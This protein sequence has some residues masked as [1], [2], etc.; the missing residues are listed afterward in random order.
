MVKLLPPLPAVSFPHKFA[1]GRQS[2]ASQAELKVSFFSH[3]FIIVFSSDWAS[4]YFIGVV[5][6]GV[7]WR[8]LAEL[9]GWAAAG[10]QDCRLLSDCR[11]WIVA[12][13]FVQSFRNIPKS[14]LVLFYKNQLPSKNAKASEEEM[15]RMLTYRERRR[16][17]SRCPMSDCS[18]GRS[19]KRFAW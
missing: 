2:G 5:H 19:R 6:R 10:L 16:D 17:R 13:S 18:R 9:A 3:N 4:G 14:A 11:H 12:I 8:W 15:P 7:F 1:C